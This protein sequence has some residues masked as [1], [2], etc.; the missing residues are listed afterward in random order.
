M[1][2]TF[3]FLAA[4]ILLAACH[5]KV[6][7]KYMSCIPVY[8]DYE[9]FRQPA[10]FLAP[11]AITKEGNIYIKDQ[12]LFVVEPDAGIHFIDNSNP[13]SP[14]NLG[15]LNLIGCT[16]MSIKDNRLYA[17]SFIDLVVFDI[18]SITAPVEV[19]RLKDLFPQA[20]PVI[21]MEKNY[22]VAA[23]D[24]NLGV[25]T[26]W[27]YEQVKEEV[28]SVPFWNNCPM[29]LDNITV[30][31]FE[32][33]N[34]TS[35]G[36][37]TAGSM[38]RFTIINNFLYVMDYGQLKPIDISNPLVPVAATPI[39]TWRQVETLFPHN[40][41]IFMG[42]TSGMLI[43]NTVNPAAPQ[44]VSSVNHTTACDPV[45][46]QDNYC[47]VTIRTGTTCMGE[48]NQLD[49]IDISDI[50][51]P[52]VVKSFQMTN[53]H[54]LGIDGSTLFICDGT[55]GLKVFN[56]ADPTTCG[57]NLIKRFKDIEATDVIP[58]NNTAIVIGEDGIRQYD[59][60]DLENLQLLSS[61]NF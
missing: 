49:V 48:L 34:S 55:D 19:A 32:S 57:D 53:P 43:Y 60:S 9:T 37:G 56:A 28:N 45:V 12:Y 15:F 2:K 8:T 3:L 14:A 31:S 40:D 44:Y 30:T 10:P 54:G 36:T 17:N 35:S 29:C 39:D 38:A 26:S 50:T 47:Y 59:Y 11:Q 33:Q 52:T 46:V 6:Q 41:Y 23:I 16:G 21:E 51:N 24:K 22:P 42:T 61:F 5:D 20:V 25:V 18:S 4:V 27:K 7:N 1:K 13:S 58:Y